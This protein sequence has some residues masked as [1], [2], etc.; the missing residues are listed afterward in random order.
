VEEVTLSRIL[1]HNAKHFRGKPM[2]RWKVEERWAAITYGEFYEWA[3]DIGT[4]LVKLGMR[5]KDRVALLSHN[6]PGWVISYFGI[7]LNGGIIVPID[8]EL[9]A[10]ELGHILNDSSAKFIILSSD[11]VETLCEVID[12]LPSLERVILLDPMMGDKWDSQASED[13]PFPD[14]GGVKHVGID[15]IRHND[16]FIHHELE[17]DDIVAIV[18]TSGTTGKSKGVVLTNRNIVS[19]I[20]SFV[21]HA[22]VD[23]GIHTLSILPINHIYEATCGILAPIYLGGTISFCE[24]L[25]KVAS[26]ISEVKP[27]FVLGVPALYD[28]MYTRI[29][30]KIDSNLFS[31]M[32]FRTKLLRGMV[33]RRIQRELGKDIRFISGGA[34]LDPEIAEGIRELGFKIFQGY[35][36]TET[37]PVISLGIR[38][39]GFKIFQGYGITETSPVI[40]FEYDGMT[41]E[42]SVGKPIPG[43]EV[44]IHDPNEEGIGEIWVEGPHVM[45]E[46]FNNPEATEEALVEGWYRTGDLG[47]I[48][49]E[50]FLYVKGRVRNLIVT[51]NGKNVYPEEVEQQ[52]LK[53]PYIEEVMVY[54]KKISPFVEEAHALVYCNQEAIDLY[55]EERGVEQMTP[56]DVEELIKSEIK[57]YGKNL[58]TY[59]RVKKFRIRD[60]PFPKT[61]TRKIKRYTLGEEIAA[62]R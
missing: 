45:K 1:R 21:E 43:V 23:E 14:M 49:D 33:T 8:K 42:G 32:S 16:T 62:N 12:L 60:E 57:E 50:G 38:E 27:N 46:Y 59:K 34:A 3:R 48:D 31:R 44:R 54:G 6:S 39:L 56:G 58:A 30:R 29:M 2:L 10:S 26:N 51:A 17:R 20:Q 15:H 36:I 61:S 13:Y 7:L 55:A 19:N 52:L 4:G 37:S 40:S 22:G 5:P 53:S 11:Y 25:K 18:Y 35:G 9:K 47:S 41:K 24:G 28:K